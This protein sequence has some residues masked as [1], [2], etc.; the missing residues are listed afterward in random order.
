MLHELVDLDEEMQVALDILIRK[1][2]RVAKSYDKKVKVKTFSTGDYVW[3]VILPM[4]QKD[5]TLGK[6]SPNW[7]GPFRIIQVFLNNAYE[8][9]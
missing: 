8:I 5:N 1:K 2:E 3:N 7:E 6:W 9:K 4:D